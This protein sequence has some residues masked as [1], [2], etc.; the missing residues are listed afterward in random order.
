MELGTWASNKASHGKKLK[1]KKKSMDLASARCTDCTNLQA[2]SSGHRCFWPPR[3]QAQG[4]G[5]V[6]GYRRLVFLFWIYQSHALLFS[7]LSSLDIKFFTLLKKHRNKT[8]SSW[9]SLHLF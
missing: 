9:L 8:V 5:C 6:F 2:V 7:E 1:N 3:V 4:C